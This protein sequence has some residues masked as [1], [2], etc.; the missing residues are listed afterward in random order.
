[1]FVTLHAVIICFGLSFLM[2]VADKAQD[3][4]VPG[5]TEDYGGFGLPDQRGARL[6]ILPNLA[7][8]ELLKTAL[9][10][11]GRRVP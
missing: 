2:S 6:L 7:R 8:P 10:G 11:G 1:M 5:A 3:Q 9:C 4:R